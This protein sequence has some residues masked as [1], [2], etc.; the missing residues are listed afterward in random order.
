MTYSQRRKRM[1]RSTVEQLSKEAAMAER[2]IEDTYREIHQLNNLIRSAALANLR[3][4]ELELL[5]KHK[6]SE[7]KEIMNQVHEAQLRDLASSAPFD[8]FILKGGIDR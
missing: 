8:V 4:K 1:K 5:L 3:I 2:V 6:E 7:Y